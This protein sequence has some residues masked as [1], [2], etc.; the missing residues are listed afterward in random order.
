MFFRRTEYCN[1]IHNSTPYIHPRPDLKNWPRQFRMFF[2]ADFLCFNC[3]NIIW[4]PILGA[5]L[6]FHPILYLWYMHPLNK[7]SSKWLGKKISFL[8]FWCEI[9]WVGE[10]IIIVILKSIKETDFFFFFFF[11]RVRS[12]F[13]S[14]MNTK[15][16]IFPRGQTTHEND[17]HSMK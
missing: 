11:L 4:P 8:K 12:N 15:I 10:S 5:K 6:H 3:W 7:L 13:V 1:F 17:V 16:S 9:W 14:L 2:S